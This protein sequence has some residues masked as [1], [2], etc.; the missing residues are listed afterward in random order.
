[1]SLM[2]YTDVYGTN[3]VAIA[4][5]ADRPVAQSASGHITETITEKSAPVM[6][7][8]ALIVLLILIRVVWELV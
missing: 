3:A 5:V 4:G 2:S 7:I 6:G 8:I 1:M